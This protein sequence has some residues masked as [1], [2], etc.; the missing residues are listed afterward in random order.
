MKSEVLCGCGC[1][2]YTELAK[3][4]DS[5]RGHVKGQGMPFIFGHASNNGPNV[6][7]RTL[8]APQPIEAKEITHQ[9]II[10]L[11]EV[12]DMEAAE[13]YDAR[14]RYLEA[15]SKRTFVETGLILAEFEDRKLQE[16]IV[17]PATG[18][19]YT[20]FNTWLMAAA[21][22]SRSSGYDAMATV[23]RL[24]AV[25]VA[26]LQAMPRCNVKTL[27]TLSTSVQ[28]Q[29]DI[30]EAAKNL[31]EEQFIAKVETRHPDQHVTN[32]RPMRLKPEKAQRK[33]IDYGLDVA[34]WAYNVPT[35]E[36]A[37]EAVFQDWLDS[38]CQLEG[39]AHLTNRLA[40][41]GRQEVAA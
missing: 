18:A 19:Y 6:Q 34:M 12:D 2:E 33:A 28:Q 13:I 39:F 3:R 4:T 37:M 24:Q 31:T 41:D 32:K 38:P 8:F 1:G 23:R 25:P 26:D 30:I 40:Y 9:D 10:A 11:R 17:D 5:R 16:K 35:R 29:P 20:S 14:V 27:S 22:V 21:P 15:Y 36:E 7:H